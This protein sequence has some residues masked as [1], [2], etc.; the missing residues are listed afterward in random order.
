MNGE[1]LRNNAVILLLFLQISRTMQIAVR[2]LQSTADR[3]I[4]HQYAAEP[5]CVAA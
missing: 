1:L 3:Q 2:R 4:I 5:E